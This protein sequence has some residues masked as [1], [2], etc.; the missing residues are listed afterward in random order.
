[1]TENL[2]EK[3]NELLG[4]DDAELVRSTLGG[5]QGSFEVLIRRYMGAVMALALREA[6]RKSDAEDIAQEA[7]VKAYRKL[8]ELA[9][10]GAFRGW[11]RRIAVNLARDISRRKSRRMEVSDHSRDDEMTNVDMPSDD[12]S[13]SHAFRMTEA[14][15][16]VLEA[17]S[18]LPPDY[19]QVAAM[20]YVE[21]LGYE[22]MAERLGLRREA[23]RKRM[24]RA[25][26]LLR[27]ELK[28]SFPE[29]AEEEKP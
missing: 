14:R 27:K 6:P 13:V 17:I 20:R 23:L 12:P 7:F 19:S 21:S 10:P 22:E 5:Q 26:L 4:P 2:N 15:E 3:E 16:L 11:V 28:G 1:M 24:H 9:D 25:N 18:V 8:S 29:L